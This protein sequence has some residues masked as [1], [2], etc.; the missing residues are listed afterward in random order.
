MTDLE[1]IRRDLQTAER[2]PVSY[3]PVLQAHVKA[4]VAELEALRAQIS[5]TKP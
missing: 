4:L 3:A 5:S 1:Q 2:Y